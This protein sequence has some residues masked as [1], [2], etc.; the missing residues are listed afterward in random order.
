M[1]S[2]NEGGSL[3]QYLAC[4]CTCV[5]SLKHAW[6]EYI[7]NL[8][9]RVYPLSLLCLFSLS[10]VTFCLYLCPKMSPSDSAASFINR[11]LRD[12]CMFEAQAPALT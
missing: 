4:Q 12:F 9:V 7:T 11:Q 5:S 8:E 3:M 2:G 10:F 6:T 1:F